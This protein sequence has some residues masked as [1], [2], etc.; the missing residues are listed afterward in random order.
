MAKL[1]P[2]VA[3]PHLL[4]SFNLLFRK[5][6]YFKDVFLFITTHIFQCQL[7]LHPNA[8]NHDLNVLEPTLPENASTENTSFFNQLIFRR[9]FFSLYIHMYNFDPCCGPSLPPGTMISTIMKL[10][11]LMKSPHK[12]LVYLP[13]SFWEENFVFKMP[14]DL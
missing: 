14:T 10:P 13:K 3:P 2:V 7:W 11:Y 1:H 5:V 4:G 12:C 8:G 9:I 6:E